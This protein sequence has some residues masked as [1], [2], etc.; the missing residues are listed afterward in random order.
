VVEY[1]GRLL[2]IEMNNHCRSSALPGMDAFIKASQPD[3]SLL[4]GGDG[5]D[6]ESFLTMS[7]ES[8]LP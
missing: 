7:P 8:W 3:K 1:R 4:I 5:L 6:T 2:V